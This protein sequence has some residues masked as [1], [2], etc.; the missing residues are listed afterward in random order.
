[1]HEWKKNNP[2]RYQKD[3]VNLKT[4]CVLSKLNTLIPCKKDYIF[5]FGV[6][7]HQMMGA[8]YL[9]WTHPINSISSGSLGVMGSSLGYA[10]GACIGV[11]GNKTIICIDGDGSFNMS[12][13]D[14][15]TIIRYKLPI[16]ILILNDNCLINGKSLGNFIF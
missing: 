6:G 11:E 7:N 15:Q 13:T 1:M 4:Q 12:L 8:Q 3:P 2:F 5:T 16:K 10:I 9:D 14:L